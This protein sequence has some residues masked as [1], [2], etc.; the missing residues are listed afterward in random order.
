MSFQPILKRRILK[1][2][3]CFFNL[4]FL[5]NNNLLL[6]PSAYYR[7]IRVMLVLIGSLYV[8]IGKN[9]VQSVLKLCIY[10]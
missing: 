4:R 10:T 3:T 7:N 1:V 2:V 6:F 9:I 8:W 5:I